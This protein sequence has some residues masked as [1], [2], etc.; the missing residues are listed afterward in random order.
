MRRIDKI[1]QE[2]QRL[3]GEKI[4]ASELAQTMNLARANVSSDLNQLHAQGIVNKTGSRPVYYSIAQTAAAPPRQNDFDTFIELN[5]SLTLCGEQA[6]AAVLYPPNGMHLMLLGDTGVG[7]SMFANLVSRYALSV[8]RIKKE[9]SFISFNCADY[10]NN[11]QL[12]VSQLFGTQKGAYTGATE[13]RPGLMEIADG[14]I[15]FLDEVHRLPPEGQEVLFTYIDRG[16]FRRMGET[17]NERKATVMLICAT[18]EQPET[19]LLQTFIRR[20]PMMIRIP[21]L[22]ERTLDERLQLITDFLLEESHKLSAGIQVSVNSM[23][24]LLGYTCPGNIGQLKSDIQLLIAQSYADSISGKSDSITI[25]SFRL[26]PHIRNG[27][28]VEQNRR[29]IWNRLSGINSRFLSFDAKE[30]NRSP[31]FT[32]EQSDIYNIIEQRTQDLRRVG[33]DEEQIQQEIGEV[34]HQ[35]YT[36]YRDNEPDFSDFERFV[37]TE[38]MATVNKIIVNAENKL[39]RTTSENIRYG[40]SMHLYNAIQRVRQGQLSSP[41]NLRILQERMPDLYDFALECLDIIEDDFNICLPQEEAGFLTLFFSEEKPVP[42][43]SIVQIIVVAHGIG[44]ATNLAATANRLMNSDLVRGFDAPLEENPGAVYE[45][46]K[47]YISTAPNI[48]EVLLLV[49]MGSLGNFA[50][51][52]ERDLGV[53]AKRFI[54]VSTLHVLEAGRKAALGYS[55]DDIYENVKSVNELALSDVSHTEYREPKDTLYV[56][57]VCTTGEGG[58][59]VIQDYLS[60]RLDLQNG[61]CQVVTLAVA[62]QAIFKTTVEKLQENGHIICVVSAFT[63]GLPVPHFELSGV[64]EGK[65]L[66]SIQKSIDTETAFIQVERTLVPLLKNINATLVFRDIREMVERIGRN[67]RKPL[68]GEVMI[69]AFCHIGCMLDKLKCGDAINPF[70]NKEAISQKYPDEIAIVQ[71]ECQRLGTKYN[72]TI[73]LEEVC[74]ITTF[75]VKDDMVIFR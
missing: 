50:Q 56:L 58:A 12:L 2:L 38:V 10:A 59:K 19:S 29:Q 53:R 34:L 55:L 5:P 9:N 1:K 72:V 69:G 36:R 49:D 61:L 51:D 3:A 46:I 21:S 18:T 15:L 35:Y 37:G 14:G 28:F 63:T 26:P 25:T 16:V 70:L 23:R 32:G 74:R 68:D 17:H 75:F 66:T 43:R 24:A 64:F 45:K 41:S 31:L 20:I 62:D 65:G 11:P 60:A 39:G 27:I 6:K 67:L 42:Q 57:A 40:L 52:L 44:T 54:L 47:E 30:T 4:T 8:G 48:K 22:A 13:N 33:L 71:R 73:P 7:K